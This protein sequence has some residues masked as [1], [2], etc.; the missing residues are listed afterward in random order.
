MER[1]GYRTGFT[2]I[3]IMIIVAI[4][5]IIMAIAGPA[6]IRAREVSRARACQANLQKVFGAK[7]IWATENGKTNGDV[8]EWDQLVVEGSTEMYLRR[9]PTCPG[10]GT[11]T[12]TAVGEDD[13]CSY[14]LPD[15]LDE[16]YRH[17]PEE[18]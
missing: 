11:Y 18:Q 4:I 6:Y 17:S 16:T 2:I 14:R 10:G 8:V 1:S 13:I 15:W 5:G 12:L 7:E 9:V 3:E